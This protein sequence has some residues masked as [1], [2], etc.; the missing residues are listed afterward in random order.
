MYGTEGDTEG[1]GCYREKE[2][3]RET[4]RQR[5]RDRKRQTAKQTDR[6]VR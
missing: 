4:E 1:A 2:G 6:K 3:D 5:Q